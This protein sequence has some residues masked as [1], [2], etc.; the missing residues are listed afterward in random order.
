MHAVARFSVVWLKRAGVALLALVGV[1]LLWGLVEPYSIDEEHESVTIP[2]LPAE[3][4]GRRIAVLADFQIGMWWANTGTI[5]RMVRR[6]VAE[7]PT[8]VLIAGDFVYK[9]DDELEEVSARVAELLAPLTR[10]GIPTYAVLG[11]HDYS[12]DY[13]DDPINP[14]VAA[15]VEETLTAIGVR[16]LLN[17][18]VPLVPGTG[19][20]AGQALYLVG[21]GDEWAGEAHAERAMSRVPTGA[22]RVVFMHNPRTFLALPAGSA[23]LAIAAHTHGGQVAVPFMRHWSWMSWVKGELVEPHGWAAAS[24]E[25]PGNRLYVN[26]G[27]GF[28]DVPIRINA[29][30]ELTTFTLTRGPVGGR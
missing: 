12:L 24:E 9:A 10:A 2:N 28:S 11:N 23:P 17:E 13:P 20:S 14:R 6:L 7:P 1:L 21:I 18:A 29:A 8:A 19:G 30:P 26:V 27:V 5:Y 22:A 25:P 16:V 4:E 15:A 3:W